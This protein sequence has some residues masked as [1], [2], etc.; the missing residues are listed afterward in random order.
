MI[1]PYDVHPRSRLY[2][3]DAL[4]G[5]QKYRLV[6]GARTVVRIKPSGCAPE[7]LL[8][9]IGGAKPAGPSNRDSR[10]HAAF[11]ATWST[12]D[13]DGGEDDNA[14]LLGPQEVVRR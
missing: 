9:L 7:R 6:E 14:P 11:A 8:P 4:R 1:N 2:R 3:E 5:V 13:R 10:R 12:G